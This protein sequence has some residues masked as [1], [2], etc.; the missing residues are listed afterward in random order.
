MNYLVT[1]GSGFIGSHLVEHLLKNGHSVINIDNYDD[2]YDYKIK[3]KN[4][5][6][7]VG[8]KAAFPFQD[9]E[10]DIQK[11]TK[12]TKAENYTLYYQDI[13]DK[14]SLTEI[15]KNHKIDLIIHLAALA[16]VRPSIERPLEYEAVNILGT[17][18]LW[19]LCK[20]FG[21][22]KFVC[23][24]SSSVYGN[25]EKIPFSETDNV[26]RPISPYAATKKSGEILGHVYHHL[27]DIDMI[28]LRFFT[29]YGPRQRPDLAIHKFTKLISENQE[30]PFYGDGSTARDYT[31]IDDI[32]DG[33]V[34]SIKYLEN[35]G[36]TYEIVNLGE[37]E[38]V[39]LNE[40]VSTIEN[41]LG[42]KALKKNLPMQP[43]DVL[44]TNADIQKARSL[45]GYDP[46]T[47]FQN[48][49]KKFVE[50]F[51]ENRD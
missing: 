1:G 11:V 4:T 20:E 35:H 36:K 30:I 19:E 37:S 28:Q 18:N 24:S 34:K 21:I 5:L 27:Y 26:D 2:F 40:M 29:V 3:I 51:L 46:T 12:D 6:E 42:Q 44:K 10:N 25:N 41:T 48:G 22:K 23:A 47:N 13:R 31:Y 15:F 7:S 9:K 43:G 8:V 17:M 32:I 50:W 16:G 49:I 33:V 45:L 39:T 14:G 38:V